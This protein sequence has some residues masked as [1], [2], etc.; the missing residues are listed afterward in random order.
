MINWVKEFAR[1]NA[2]PSSVSR[3]IIALKSYIEADEPAFLLELLG[4]SEEAR[5][6][7][8]ISCMKMIPATQCI[9]ALIQ[10]QTPINT[11]FEN[12]PYQCSVMEYLDDLKSIYPNSYRKIFKIIL[13]NYT[14]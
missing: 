2:R 6:Y 11:T 4:D 8:L 3:P 13:E 7:A 9:K 12:N 1:L 10:I 14:A 5:I